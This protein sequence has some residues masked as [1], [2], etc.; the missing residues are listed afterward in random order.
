M[1]VKIIS[2]RKDALVVELTI[3][4]ETTM[5]DGEQAIEKA[6][7]EAGALASGELLKR[8]DTDGSAIVMGSTKL[9]SKGKVEKSYQTPYGQTRIKRHV[10]QT[11]MFIK[12]KGGSHLLSA[13]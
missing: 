11:P 1:T 2:I 5:L 12:H 13:G 8:F 3:P 6:L 4:L 10:Y 7:N 9:T